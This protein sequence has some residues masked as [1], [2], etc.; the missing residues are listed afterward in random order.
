M[1][2]SPY[3]ALF[4]TV[5]TPLALLV[6]FIATSSLQVDAISVPSSCKIS[7][8]TRSSVVSFGLRTHAEL[9]SRWDSWASS[10]SSLD[11]RTKSLSE[12]ADSFTAGLPPGRQIEAE[13]SGTPR[14]HSRRRN[15]GH[16]FQNLVQGL[17]ASISNH[18]SPMDGPA[19]SGAA[20]GSRSQASAT[21]AQGNM[22]LVLPSDSVFAASIVEEG[23]DEIGIKKGVVR[24]RASL[25]TADVGDIM[26]MK[27]LNEMYL[28]E[29][30]PMDFWRQTILKHPDLS[31]VCELPDGQ[32]VGYV[33]GKL[34]YTYAPRPSASRLL[35]ERQRRA[36]HGG[37][38][39]TVAYDRPRRKQLSEGKIMSLCV[40][41]NFRGNGIGKQLLAASI[42]AFDREAKADFV[43]L[44]VR[45]VTNPNAVALY[46]KMEFNVDEVVPNYYKDGE[47]ALVMTRDLR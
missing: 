33:L 18:N 23:I 34:E 6:S 3:V 22:G 24:R 30:Y 9:G 14:G 10:Q 26:W 15:F 13:A 20:T 7:A 11:S 27:H 38:P 36:E 40:S 41:R 47:S 16:G 44:R 46:K 39:L 42:N 17:R 2:D 25:R 35:R 31:F 28:P 45:Q 21:K 4:H 19:S 37:Q 32:L 5:P 8:R 43:S 1:Q 12:G 29:N